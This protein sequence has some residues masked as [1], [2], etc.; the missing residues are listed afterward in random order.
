V[1]DVPELP[2]LPAV[3]FVPEV[4]DVP[5]GCCATI[6]NT[7]SPPVKLKELVTKVA[8]NSQYELG[9]ISLPVPNTHFWNWSE[10]FWSCMIIVEPDGIN[11][12]N[13]STSSPPLV[14]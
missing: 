3:P 6:N 7:F 11:P 9:P 2:P 13:T 5:D 14:K 1:P 10:L 4:P 8:G 12:K